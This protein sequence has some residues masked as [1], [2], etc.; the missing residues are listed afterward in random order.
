M[1]VFKG[2]GGSDGKTVAVNISTCQ[3]TVQLVVG[4]FS[5]HCRKRVE[6]QMMCLFFYDTSHNNKKKVAESKW[7]KLLT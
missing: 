2:G 1:I 5:G 7:K 6:K 3:G 4:I